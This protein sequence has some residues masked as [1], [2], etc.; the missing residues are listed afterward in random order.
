MH[1]WPGFESQV[2]AA[3]SS[4]TFSADISLTDEAEGDRYFVGSEL[5]LT[6]R[7]VRHVCDPVAKALSVSNMPL[8]FGDFRAIH[9]YHF[10]VPELTLTM[11]QVVSYM[12]LSKLRYGFISTFEPTVFIKRDQN[13]AFHLS[14]P[15]SKDASTTSP[16]ECFAGFAFIAAHNPNNEEKVGIDLRLL[17][18][19]IEPF[20]NAS[21]PPSAYRSRVGD[22]TKSLINIR[23][24][25]EDTII[26]GDNGVAT[27]FVTCT[28]RLSTSTLRRQGNAVYEVQSGHF[29]YV[30]KCWSRN[31]EMRYA[32]SVIRG[33]WDTDRRFAK[34]SLQYTNGS[35]S[36]ERTNPG[37]SFG[38]GEQL[39]VLWKSL[40]DIC[41]EIPHLQRVLKG[42]PNPTIP[43][44]SPSGSWQAQRDVRSG[45][46]GGDFGG[47]SGS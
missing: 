11:C 15:T 21:Q 25:T 1:Q 42:D 44:Y 26:F 37:F 10:S 24:L 29:R 7:F 31:H 14:M 17:H 19:R 3:L 35:T 22:S 23:G 6:T 33:F 4:L 43:L 18:S 12:R 27:G 5:R 38:F 8:P 34:N 9:P 41:R 2:F 30:A 47:L 46:A 20:F 40:P 39:F 45:D 16:R 36:F 28:T 13:Y 32:A